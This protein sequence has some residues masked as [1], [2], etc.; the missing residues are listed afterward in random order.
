MGNPLTCQKR[1]T[2]SIKMSLKFTVLLLVA[3]AVVCVLASESME[4]AE[5]AQLSAE[6]DDYDEL[7]SMEDAKDRI[8]VACTTD[9][10][11]SGLLFKRFCRTG[12]FGISRCSIFQG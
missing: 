10:D 6:Y 9:A 5:S 3:S 4:S 11:C 12:L 1:E 2:R 8:L 7:V